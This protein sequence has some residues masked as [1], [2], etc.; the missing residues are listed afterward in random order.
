MTTILPPSIQEPTSAQST[1]G[2]EFPG[3]F[4]R[5]HTTTTRLPPPSDSQRASERPKP[6][7]LPSSEREGSHPGEHC[8][9]VGPLPGNISE[10]SV[11][12][13]P[14]ERDTEGK[15]AS[16]PASRSKEV[17]ADTDRRDDSRDAIATAVPPVNP[18][19]A[20][21]A[22]PFVIKLPSER[23]SKD[24]ATPES[25]SRSKE[26]AADTG[27]GDDSLEAAPTTVSPTSL[28]PAPAVDPTGP[29]A[30][31]VPEERAS[32]DEVIPESASR[33]KELAADTVRGDDSREA[34]PTTVS[35]TSLP[36]APDV[37]P[38]GPSPFAAKVPEERT[39]EGKATS[40]SAS[41]SKE[42]VADTG[43]GSDA[44]ESVTAV[45]GSFGTLGI[46]DQDSPDR[47]TDSRDAVCGQGPESQHTESSVSLYTFIKL[48]PLSESSTVYRCFV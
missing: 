28:P 44:R 41:R 3:A 39:S 14:D 38:A 40:E 36:P 18:L 26:L 21:F 2:L 16:A 35:P 9:G 7:S 17:F 37:I 46:T 31:K 27:R 4:P 48:H 12:K 5:E 6:I 29:F 30:S 24:E 11:A 10:T 34:V 8:G 47:K 23:A 1:P 19:A 33:S 15:A 43:R 25:A 13:L 32:K 22:A 42:L 20:P 45:A